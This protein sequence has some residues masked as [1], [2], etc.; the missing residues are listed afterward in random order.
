MA[1]EKT[2]CD[3][4]YEK[5]LQKTNEEIRC[6]MDY[7]NKVVSWKSGGMYIVKPEEWSANT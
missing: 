7:I 1:P 3:D 2:L 6:V 5:Y 4:C